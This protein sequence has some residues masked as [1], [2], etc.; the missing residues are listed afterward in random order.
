M[1]IEIKIEVVLKTYMKKESKIETAK[2]VMIKTAI[3]IK[4]EIEDKW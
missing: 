3:R 2:V 4:V 1:E